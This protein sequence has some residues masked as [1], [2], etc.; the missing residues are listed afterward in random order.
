MGFGHLRTGRRWG[1]GLLGG[2]AFF[3]P[4]HG[5][6]SGKGAVTQRING[7]KAIWAQR[8][9]AIWRGAFYD[10]TKKKKV[11]FYPHIR[12]GTNGGCSFGDR[13][14]YFLAGFN[15]K[16]LQFFFFGS[17]VFIVAARGIDEMIVGSHSRGAAPKFPVCQYYNFDS[18]SS[19]FF[20]LSIRGLSYFAY[21]YLI[22][23]HK[24]AIYLDVMCCK[25]RL[26]RSEFGP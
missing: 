12:A 16:V 3:G 18:W 20:R 10:K 8:G 13:P 2:D 24:R 5:F 11:F 17:L 4:L 22:W 1:P 26:P 7:S 14:W 23:I 9:P 19:F 6:S 25:T 15:S 21:A